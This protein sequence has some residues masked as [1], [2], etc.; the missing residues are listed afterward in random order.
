LATPACRTRSEAFEAFRGWLHDEAA[1]H[2]A[3]FA[4]FWRR[5]GR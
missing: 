4:T 2:R 5:Q 1:R 3:A